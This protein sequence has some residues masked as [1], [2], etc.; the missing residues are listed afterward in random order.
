MYDTDIGFNGPLYSNYREHQESLAMSYDRCHAT[1][2]RNIVGSDLPDL[3]YTVMDVKLGFL[4]DCIF[5]DALRDYDN[6]I[7]NGRYEYRPVDAVIGE[8]DEAYQ[9]FGTDYVGGSKQPMDTYLLRWGDRIVVLSLRQPP[10]KEH[11][12]AIVEKLKP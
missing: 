10:T 4:T 8:A 9:E 12:A 11:I 5:E 2:R 7:F 3:Y 6:A 1:L